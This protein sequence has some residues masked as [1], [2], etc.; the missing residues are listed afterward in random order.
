MIKNFREV[1]KKIVITSY[2]LKPADRKRWYPTAFHNFEYSRSKNYS[3]V[4]CVMASS[5]ANTY[6]PFYK[7]H[8]EKF[9]DGGCWANN[10]SMAGAVEARKRLHVKPKDMVILNIGTILENKILDTANPKLGLLQWVKSGLID[11]FLDGAAM[12]AITYYCHHLIDCNYHLV[13]LYQDEV[14]KLDEYKKVDRLLEIAD[15]VDLKPTLDW[16]QGFWV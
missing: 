5:A 9:C 10:P 15:S 11:I 6:F 1:E 13:D 14:I 2:N 7:F 8:G 16:M 12:D 3:F 4:D